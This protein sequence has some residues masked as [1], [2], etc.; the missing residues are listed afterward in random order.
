MTAKQQSRLRDQRISQVAVELVPE[1]KDAGDNP[2]GSYSVKI[3]H[4]D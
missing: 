2:C 1:V 3:Q 4:K